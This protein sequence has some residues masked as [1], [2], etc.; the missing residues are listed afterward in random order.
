LVLG[1]WVLRAVQHP[2][3][4]S[5]TTAENEELRRRLGSDSSNSSRPPSSDSQY[6]KPKPKQSGLP[7]RSGRKPS[8]QPVLDAADRP[9]TSVPS[10][11]FGYGVVNPA[12]A[13]TAALRWDGPA[14]R[15]LPPLRGPERI[16]PPRDDHRRRYRHT[17]HR[18]DRLR[19]FVKAALV[20]LLVVVVLPAVASGADGPGRRPA[21]LGLRSS[22]GPR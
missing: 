6:D 12:R 3:R 18:A 21:R 5:R 2:Q 14:H 8:N 19:R 22:S 4:P 20:A 7:G 13:L 16:P 10:P 17:D 15:A 11:E 9:G 1:L